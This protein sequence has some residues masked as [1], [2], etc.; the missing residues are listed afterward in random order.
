MAKAKPSSSSKSKKP[1]LLLE[2]INAKIVD[3]LN[4]HSP[5]ELTFSKVSRWTEVPRSTLYYYYGNTKDKMILAAVRAAVTQFLVLSEPPPFTQFESWESYQE[6]LL[7]KASQVVERFPWAPDLY[8][9]YRLDPGAIG[10]LMRDLEENY[11]RSRTDAWLHFYPN[12]K[13]EWA[14]IRLTSVIKLGLLYGLQID[15]ELWRGQKN[16]KRREQLIQLVTKFLKQIHETN[17]VS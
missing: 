8:F 12:K 6:E 7:R 11:F 2:E 15:P 1:K 5:L 17:W 13:P 3:M 9:R 16:E 4:R 14:S 10:Q